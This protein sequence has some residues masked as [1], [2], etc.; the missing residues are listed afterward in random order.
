M[1]KRQATVHQ[2][3]CRNNFGS[4]PLKRP[5]IAIST[6][7]SSCKSKGPCRGRGQEQQLIFETC[8]IGPQRHSFLESSCWKSPSEP[9]NALHPTPIRQYL[10]AEHL[11]CLCCDWNLPNQTMRKVSEEYSNLNNIL[12]NLIKSSIHCVASSKENGSFR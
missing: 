12:A 1:T 3:F 2:G 5:S 7:C 6:V 4:S 8:L 10:W 9:S 11:A